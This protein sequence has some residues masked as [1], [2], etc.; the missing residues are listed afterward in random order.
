MR[1]LPPGMNAGIGAPG[2]ADRD[3]LAGERQDRLLD[4]AWNRRTVVLPLPADI[5]GTVI[6]DG[7]AIA[8]HQAILARQRWA[9]RAGIGRGERLAARTLQSRQPHR[10]FSAGD[11]ESTVKHFSGS[12]FPFRH[13]GAST[14]TRSRRPEMS[15]SNQAPGKGERPRI[16]LCTRRRPGKIDA[17]LFLRNLGG[18]GERPLAPAGV[19]GSSPASSLAMASVISTLR[20]GISRSCNSPAVI[21]LVDRNRLRESHGTVSSPIVHFHHHHTGLTVAG[22]DRP[23][24][25]RPPPAS[26]AGARHGRY[27]SRSGSREYFLRQ[28]QPV[29]DD[30]RHVRTE[31]RKV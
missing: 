23:L 21:G 8:G 7:Q 4:R 9:C 30:D 24:D 25:R 2:A 3:R 19:S 6:F 10:A 14:L 15:S 22:H 17:G 13:F 26:A 1:H 18:I 28:Q 29:G 27:S 11:A 20:P 12:T 16:W 31:S 5:I